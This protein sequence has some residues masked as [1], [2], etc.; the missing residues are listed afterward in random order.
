MSSLIT[1]DEPILLILSS[2]E[3][4]G[5]DSSDSDH[6]WKSEEMKEPISTDEDDVD[7]SKFPQ[8]NEAA[9]FG[10]VS[11]ELGMEFSNLS[12]F[13]HAVKEYTINCGRPIKWVKNDG[14][15]VRAKCQEQECK[16]E[17]YCAESKGRGSYQVKTFNDK[18]I[19]C[20]TNR[21]PQAD[22]KWLVQKL[23]VKLRDQ[24]KIT[25]VE[26]FDFV[27]KEFKVIIDRSMIFRALKEARELVEGSEREQYGKMWDYAHE[28]IRSNPGSLI[29]MDTIPQPDSGPQFQ[30]FFVCLDACK[31][32]F[33]A[34][35]RP[36]IGLDGCFL[37]GYFGG[38]LLSA[39][40][41]DANKH[42]FVIA[43]AIV[44]VENKE[45]WKWFLTLLHGEI[46]DY[47]QHG[48]IFMSDMQK[49]YFAFGLF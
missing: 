36:F 12:S 5:D 38:Q 18:H 22:K 43:Y 6:S 20:R 23:E 31:R 39:V 4:P 42:I 49:V 11:L 3:V 14:D 37:K 34:G 40:G 30:R 41:Q 48:W 28:L 7:T 16:W 29:K 46:G 32:G 35:C 26:V 19:C 13:K 8:F 25:H 24:P 33:K 27:K 45:N 9:K 44:D 2:Q 15:R 17:I 47:M 1:E 10:N 21:L